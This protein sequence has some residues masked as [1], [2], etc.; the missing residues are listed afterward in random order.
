MKLNKIEVKRILNRPKG[1]KPL[2]KMKNLRTKKIIGSSIV[3]MALLLSGCGIYKSISSE[4]TALFIA[5]NS[6]EI[7]R[8]A[9]KVATILSIY[10]FAV[11]DVGVSPQN[12]RSSVRSRGGK[13][14]AVDVLPGEHTIKIT[15]S[16][17]AS[18]KIITTNVP[19]TYKFEAGQVY[20]LTLTM[21][22]LG[23]STTTI[24]KKKSAKEAEKIATLR[25]NAV[26]EKYLK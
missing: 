7:I 10:D 12:M 6:D 1:H 19:V 15:S 23:V 5:Y 22:P 21:A 26:F 24:T 11:D 4:N 16:V 8:E 17:D 13:S 25:K 18:G 9:E 2:N 20:E 3:A 14:L